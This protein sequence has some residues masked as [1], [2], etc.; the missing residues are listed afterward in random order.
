MELRHKIAGT[1]TGVGTTRRHDAVAPE[2]GT[3]FIVMDVMEAAAVREAK[4]SRSST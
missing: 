4:A 1:A 3:A 2:R